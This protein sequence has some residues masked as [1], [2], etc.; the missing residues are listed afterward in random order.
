M[1]L[2]LAIVTP[3]SHSRRV[4]RGAGA[5][6]A[7]GLVALAAPVAAAPSGDAG[8][9]AITA[10]EAPGGPMQAGSGK[11]HSDRGGHPARVT[12]TGEGRSAAVPD[13]ATVTLGVEVQ[14]PTAKEAMSQNAE[15]QQAVVGALKEAG[16][17]PRDIQTSGLGLSA[18][19]DYP[20]EGKAPVITGYRASNTVTVRVRDLSSLGGLLDDL[21]NAGA[22]EIRG[23]AFSR[24]DSS[25]SEAMALEHAVENARSHA[26][27]IAAAS[28]MQL[29]PLVTIGENSSGGDMPRPVMMRAMAES[30]GQSTP[31]ESGELT[32]TAQ[33]TAVWQLLPQDDAQDGPQDGAQED[34]QDDQQGDAVDAQPDDAGQEAAPE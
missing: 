20:G 1:V 28:G 34:A 3:I 21:V 23:I 10:G 31:V 7:L 24:E 2:P 17:E 16:V 13:L 26:E 15:R 27:A 8:A 18:V 19:Q 11:V 6:L 30:A 25:D 22:N 33:V 5:A 32:V 12:V 14:A 9:A 29:G 4:A